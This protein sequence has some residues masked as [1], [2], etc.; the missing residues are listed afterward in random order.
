MRREH[1]VINNQRPHWLLVTSYYLP[2]KRLLWDALLFVVLHLRRY[3]Q[4]NMVSKYERKTA[5]YQK[6][7]QVLSI[8]IQTV[9]IY[10]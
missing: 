4:I 7:F 1:D 2:V 9:F 6:T 5:F 10:G 3:L 8:D